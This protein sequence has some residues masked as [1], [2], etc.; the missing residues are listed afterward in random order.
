MGSPVPA[1]F[2][3]GHPT[4]VVYPAKPAAWMA[5]HVPSVWKVKATGGGNRESRAVGIV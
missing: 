3:L 2:L 5:H 1:K 4:A